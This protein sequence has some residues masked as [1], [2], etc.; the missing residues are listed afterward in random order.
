MSAKTTILWSLAPGKR[1]RGLFV[2]LGSCVMG[3][4]R[5]RPPGAPYAWGGGAPG[6]RVLSR[7]SALCSLTI[8]SRKSDRGAA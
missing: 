8:N 1:T 6:V 4:A 3:G 7:F 5:E 2:S